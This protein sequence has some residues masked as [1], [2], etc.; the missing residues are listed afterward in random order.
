MAEFT[1]Y[2]AP[3]E[4][5]PPRIAPYLVV[6]FFSGGGYFRAQVDEDAN[7]TLEQWEKFLNGVAKIP[8]CAAAEL[9]EG[10]VAVRRLLPSVTYEPL[11]PP[12]PETFSAE[13]SA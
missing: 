6:S 12:D 8:G 1:E 4:D 11:P 13:A 5:G 10:A 2:A 3:G 7:M 9:R